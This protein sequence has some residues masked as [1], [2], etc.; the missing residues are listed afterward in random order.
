VGFNY[1]VTTTSVDAE[2]SCWNFGSSFTCTEDGDSITNLDDLVLSAGGGAGIMIALGSSPQ[3][4]R[5]DLSVRYLYGGEADYLTEGSIRWGE[6]LVVLEPHRS[7][8]DMIA[9]YIGLSFGR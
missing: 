4:V 3:S 5:L 6:S 9:V 7:R 2:E 8:T 1:L